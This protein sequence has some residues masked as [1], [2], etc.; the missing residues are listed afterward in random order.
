MAIE[1]RNEERLE[2]PQVRTGYV[3]L[4]VLG[5]LA[6][7]GGTI[8]MVGTVYYWQVRVQSFPAPQQFPQPRVQTG[9][10]AQLRELQKRQSSRLHVYRWVDQK[11]GLIEVPIDRAMQI[12]ATEGMQAYAPLAPAQALSAPSA[13]AERLQTPQAGAP[14]ASPPAPAGGKQ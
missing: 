2:S 12:L 4:C 8:A 14:A 13:G 10:R 3:L 9:Q 5:G 7:L 11:N 1:A 6:I